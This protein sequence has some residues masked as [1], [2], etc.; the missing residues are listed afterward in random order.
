MSHLF[1]FTGENHQALQEKLKFWEREF[2][3]KHS[4]NNL[5]KFNEVTSDNLGQVINAIES[6][7]FLAEKRLIIIKGLPLGTESKVKIETDS[8]EE[9]L[10]DIP[11]TSLVLFVSPK[12]DKRG[13]FYKFL[14]KEAQIEGFEVPKGIELK[15]WVQKKLA[16]QQKKI[17]NSALDLLILYCAEDVTRLASEIEKLCLLEQSTL[18]ENDIEKYIS[19]TPE[20]KIFKSLDLISQVPLPRVLASFQDLSKSSESMM[21]VFFMIVRQFRLLLQIRY[22]MDQGINRATIQKRLKLAPF[23][24]NMLCQQAGSF[25]TPVLKRAYQQLAELDFQ[26]KTGQIPSYTNNEELL[27]LKIDQFLCSLY[28]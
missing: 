16:Q 19:P 17:S 23:Q 26:I 14:N 2:I 24:V 1:L 22:L 15:N 5:E 3:K 20:A 10:L 12:P 11:E 21:L 25:Q 6:Q 18:D 8:L 27:Q 9:C 13:R 7:P 4:E 28:E